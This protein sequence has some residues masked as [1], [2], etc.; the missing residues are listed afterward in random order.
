MD[1]SHSHWFIAASVPLSLWDSRIDRRRAVLLA[2]QTFQLC[3][4][5]SPGGAGFEVKTDEIHFPVSSWTF[6]LSHLTQCFVGGFPQLSQST[7]RGFSFFF[8]VL[9]LPMFS[10]C[11][12]EAAGGSQIKNAVAKVNVCKAQMDDSS[13]SILV[14]IK[15]HDV[16]VSL[17]YSP[18]QT[19][20][21]RVTWWRPPCVPRAGERVTG[22]RWTWPRMA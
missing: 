20:P 1:A 2:V 19:R 9:T 18:P 7:R 17:F 21:E 4:T 11:S 5:D 13:A 15:F 14:L 8:S 10:Q 22:G 3:Y 12:R 16:R 6:P